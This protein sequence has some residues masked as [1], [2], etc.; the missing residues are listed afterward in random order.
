MPAQRTIPA[1]GGDTTPAD[2]TATGP[3]PVAAPMAMQWVLPSLVTVG[4]TLLCGI[5]GVIWTEIKASEAR[6]NTQIGVLRE[7]LSRLEGKVDR[8]L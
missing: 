3:V 5:G 4:F 2:A 8:L 6:L 1:T 7:D